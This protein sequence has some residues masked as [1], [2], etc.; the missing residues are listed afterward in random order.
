M[1]AFSDRDGITISA[2][3]S[4]FVNT[5]AV[6]NK[7]Y[8]ATSVTKADRQKA[9][10]IAGAEKSVGIVYAENAQSDPKKLVQ[11]LLKTVKGRESLEMLEKPL[12]ESDPEVLEEDAKYTRKEFTEG[13]KQAK[14][15]LSYLPVHS[16]FITVD[17]RYLKLLRRH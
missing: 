1:D 3:D 13:I 6:R 15:P 10:G 5:E 8:S 14:Q 7:H 12:K 17:T 11:E 9:L 16:G 4:W 2:L